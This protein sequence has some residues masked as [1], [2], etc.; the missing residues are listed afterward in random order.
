MKNFTDKNLKK[1]INQKLKNINPFFDN[2][3]LTNLAFILYKTSRYSKYYY[4]TIF[5]KNKNGS[6]Q[7]AFKKDIPLLPKKIITTLMMNM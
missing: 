1:I 5:H 4:H 6:A 3:L 2:F 7:P